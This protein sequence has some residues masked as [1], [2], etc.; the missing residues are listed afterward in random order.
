MS[1]QPYENS[2]GSRCSP[3]SVPLHA[4]KREGIHALETKCNNSVPP[5]VVLLSSGLILDGIFV[6]WRRTGLTRQR[7]VWP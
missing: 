2:Y 7:H 6:D 3:P 1:S 5:L 4:R